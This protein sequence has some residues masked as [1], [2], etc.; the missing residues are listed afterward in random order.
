MPEI[1]MASVKIPPKVLVP[2][3]AEDAFTSGRLSVERLKVESK[4]LSHSSE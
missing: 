1:L 2:K 3:L 4:S